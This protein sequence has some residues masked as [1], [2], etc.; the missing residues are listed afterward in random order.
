MATFVKRGDTWR[1]Q[2]RMKGV[3]KSATF[4]KKAQA[5]AWAQETEAEILAGKI[6]KSSGRLFR[7][8]VDKYCA[9]ILP[10]KKGASKELIRATA[11]CKRLQF[12]GELIDDVTPE[13]ITTWKNQR[14]KEV[15]DSTVN[16]EL[17]FLSAIFQA[18]VKEWK[19]IREN[20]VHGVKRPPKTP[21]VD[22]LI[23]PEEIEQVISTFG[24]SEGTTPTMTYQRVGLAFLFAIE[25]GMR[26]GEICSLKHEDINI[27]KRFAI[28][29]TSKNGDCRY[30][31]LSSKSVHILSRLPK[32]KS[33]VFGLTPAISD[34]LWRK[35]RAKAATAL[36]SI[37]TLRFHDTRHHAV[38]MLAKKLD[39][40]DLARMIGHRDINSLMIYYNATPTDIA[41]RLG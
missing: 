13:M 40:L 39:V 22:R 26:I 3:S 34:A 31:P 20:P 25:T 5:T 38:T 28:I 8:A 30:V 16:R 2:V 27:E 24:I 17:N 1:A 12:I 23:S 37:A 10:T 21:P 32:D 7:H 11:I 41:E 9:E 14:L 4:D 36:P 18:A 35:F 19:W 15:K 6:G 33:T 29:R